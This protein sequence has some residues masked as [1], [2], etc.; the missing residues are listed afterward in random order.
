MDFHTVEGVVCTYVVRRESAV[1]ARTGGQSFV[2]RGVG[3]EILIVLGDVAGGR[4][5]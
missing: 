4:K 5:Q 3:V 2:M 1:V